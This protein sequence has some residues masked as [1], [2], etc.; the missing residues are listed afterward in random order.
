M[1]ILGVLFPIAAASNNARGVCA[2]NECATA[3]RALLDAA[4]PPFAGA[5]D[6]ATKIAALVS[7]PRLD[8]APAA[9]SMLGDLEAAGVAARGVRPCSPDVAAFRRSLIEL[10][11]AAARSATL[12]ATSARLAAGPTQREAELAW[13]TSLDEMRPLAGKAYDAFETVQ[14]RLGND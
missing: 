14:A 13:R 7:R 12:R 10:G 9:V 11:T 4:L 2:G 8:R 5:N 1:G 3:D 6:N